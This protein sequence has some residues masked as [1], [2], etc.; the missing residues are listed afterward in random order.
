MSMKNVKLVGLSQV[1][2]IWMSGLCCFD[3]FFLESSGGA[4]M[5]AGYSQG[6]RPVDWRRHS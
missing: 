6:N 5:S 4:V 2:V 1:P 3:S